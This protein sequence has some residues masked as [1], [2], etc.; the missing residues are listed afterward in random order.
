MGEYGRQWAWTVAGVAGGGFAHRPAG[1]VITECSVQTR[2]FSS[3]KK[4]L[5]VTNK[6]G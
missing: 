2:K 6:A 1:R 4:F 5:F 3:R